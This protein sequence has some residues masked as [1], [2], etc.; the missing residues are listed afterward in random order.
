MTDRE[1]LQQAL[2]VLED[3]D[4]LIQ[5]QYNGSKKAM[6]DLT[7][8]AQSTPPIIEAIKARLAHPELEPVAWFMEGTFMDGTPSFIQVC[9]TDP[10]FYTPLYTTPPKK[11]WV[12]LTDEEIYFEMPYKDTLF[13]FARSIE[14]KLKEKNDLG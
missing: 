4:S 5:H 13:E 7:I 12:G 8:C 9:E 1:L 2:D 10:E 6:S 3:W 11:E 14:A